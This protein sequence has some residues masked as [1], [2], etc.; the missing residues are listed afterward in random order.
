MRRDATIGIDAQGILVHGG[1]LCGHT[2]KLQLVGGRNHVVM[3]QRVVQTEVRRLYHLSGNHQCKILVLGALMKRVLA[4]TKLHQVS[5]FYPTSDAVTVVI[6]HV[7]PNLFNTKAAQRQQ[8]CAEKQVVH[9]FFIPK[10]L[11]N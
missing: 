1:L 6:R 5:F 3:C 8:F 9:I 7:L 2:G 11:Q 4:T 10:T